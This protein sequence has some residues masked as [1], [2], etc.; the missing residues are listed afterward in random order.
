M[1][2]K[3]ITVIESLYKVFKYRLP[4]IIIAYS[5]IILSKYNYM[6]TYQANKINSK[7]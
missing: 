6:H 7:G 5:P 1:W 3:C 4:M 2:Y